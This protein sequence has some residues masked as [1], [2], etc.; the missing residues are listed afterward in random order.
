MNPDGLVVG[1][2]IEHLLLGR[3]GDCYERDGANALCQ[4]FN[5]TA[6]GWQ[7]CFVADEKPPIKGIRNHERA[8]GAADLYDVPDLSLLCP[9]DRRTGRMQRNVDGQLFGFG[10]EMSRG[11][12]TRLETAPFAGHM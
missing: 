6:D 7:S 8:S 1:S 11:E 9:V 5:L 3:T 2:R 12:V 4:G 10:I